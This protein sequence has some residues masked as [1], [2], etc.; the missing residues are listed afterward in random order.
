VKRERVIKRIYNY[1]GEA[2][3]EIQPSQEIEGSTV[4]DVKEHAK[5]L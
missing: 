1:V 3:S 2:S 4:P 5:I